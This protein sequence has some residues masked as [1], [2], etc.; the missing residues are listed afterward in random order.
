MFIAAPSAIY[1]FL[2]SSNEV[3]EIICH[4]DMVMLLRT[5]ACPSLGLFGRSTSLVEKSIFSNSTFS[6]PG[7]DYS[8]CHVK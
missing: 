1:D 8:F 5:E 6:L 7:L 3:D 2:H 4:S